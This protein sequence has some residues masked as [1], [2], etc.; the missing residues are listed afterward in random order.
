MSDPHSVA[1]LRSPSTDIDGRAPTLPADLTNGRDAVGAARQAPLV[2]PLD[3][4]VPRL[5][6]V[7]AIPG[8]ADVEHV[9]RAAALPKRVSHRQFQTTLDVGQGSRG[10]CWAFAGIAALE[11]AYARVGV[12]ENLSEQYLFHISKAHENHRNGGGVNSLIGFQGSAD[13]V[14]HLA[15]WAV[16]QGGPCSLHRPAGVAGVGQ[17]DTRHRGWVGWRRRRHA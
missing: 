17:R 4:F 14:H 16:P 13:V 8:P 1:V 9:L 3:T 11:A 12:R 7:A 5:E 2:E 6:R 15:Y 10:S